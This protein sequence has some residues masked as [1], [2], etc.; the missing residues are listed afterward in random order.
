M[1][2]AGTGGGIVNRFLKKR[3]D[4]SLTNKIIKILILCLIFIVIGLILITFNIF[5]PSGIML[6]MIGVVISIFI[7]YYAAGS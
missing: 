3:N 6:I 7:I 1:S 5:P 2:G 4:Q